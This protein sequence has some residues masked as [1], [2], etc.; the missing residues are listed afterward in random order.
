MKCQRHLKYER[1]CFDDCPPS[2]PVSLLP[3]LS[4][5]A[6]LLL[7][8]PSPHTIYTTENIA[9]S[10]Y[11]NKHWLSA[12]SAVSTMPIKCTNM[13]PA[14]P[15]CKKLRSLIRELDTHRKDYHVQT[16]ILY[17]SANTL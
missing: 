15:Y 17:R 2:L 1:N 7:S 5:L 8:L 10:N 13:K 6:P 4:F 9:N 14:V 12:F 11:I 16:M 3:P